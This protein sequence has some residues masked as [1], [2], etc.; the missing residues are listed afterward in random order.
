LERLTTAK[1]VEFALKDQGR[2]KSWLANQLGFSRPVLYD[3]LRNNAWEP[4]EIEKLQS[5]GLI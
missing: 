2:N 1:K 5:L 4:R 3:R